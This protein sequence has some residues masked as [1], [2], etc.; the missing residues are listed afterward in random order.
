MSALWRGDLPLA[1][2]FWTWT[3]TIGLFVNV[4]TT[5]LFLGLLSLDRPWIALLFGYGLS[6]PYNLVAVV[7]VWRAAERD[8]DPGIHA[9]L[10][11]GA[12]VILMGVLSFL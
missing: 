7:G 8:Q 2:A 10:A 6:L 5:I 4:F 1:E 3:V 12:S 11:R 9:D